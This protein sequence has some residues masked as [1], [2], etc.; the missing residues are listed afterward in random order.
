MLIVGGGVAGL[1]TARALQAR[2]LGSTVV[3]RQRAPVPGPGLMFAVD[4]EASW[5]AVA[6]SVCVRHGHL[7]GGFEAK[8][9]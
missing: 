5:S 8:H 9:V 4:E 1:A 6:P 2:G 7:V 3:E